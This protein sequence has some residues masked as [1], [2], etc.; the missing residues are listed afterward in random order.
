M[1][2]NCIRKV[3]IMKLSYSHQIVVRG[4]KHIAA[5]AVCL[6][7]L[8]APSARAVVGYT[9]N[10]NSTY[11]NVY[12]NDGTGS[13]SAYG[14]SISPYTPIRTITS[15]STGVGM[16]LID[17]GPTSWLQTGSTFPLGPQ[18]ANWSDVWSSIG[19]ALAVVQYD[20]GKLFLRDQIL[21]PQHMLHHMGQ[22]CSLRTLPAQGPPN[23]DWIGQRPTL[24]TGHPF[25]RAAR[26][27]S[28]IK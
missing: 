6:A 15:G 4:S 8:L 1:Q 26:T 7:F 23:C 13:S 28:A 22:A 24:I 27:T 9:A 12:F 25:G 19:N 20:Q 17:Y 18:S 11:L 3:I 5:L 21:F 2:F 10:A 16:P 14:T